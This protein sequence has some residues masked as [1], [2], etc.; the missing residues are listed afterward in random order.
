M[1]FWGYDEDV[2]E[3]DVMTK[4]LKKFKK[5]G[6]C[7]GSSEVAAE[8]RMCE[9]CSRRG[10]NGKCHNNTTNRLENFLSSTNCSKTRPTALNGSPSHPNSAFDFD[11]GYGVFSGS[12]NKPSVLTC[13][14]EPPNPT[15]LL[16][17][18]IPSSQD[19]TRRRGCGEG[20]DTDGAAEDKD[21]D[22]VP[23]DEEGDLDV[24]EGLLYL[25]N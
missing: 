2:V 6:C 1:M 12:D 18:T 10:S 3:V 17:T 14:E 22:E 13:L 8:R 21:G 7:D 16:S 4:A 15:T 23:E 11:L 20:G 19:R 9:G 5:K 24:V 25:V